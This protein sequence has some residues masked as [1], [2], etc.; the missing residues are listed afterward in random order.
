MIQLQPKY[1]LN[2]IKRSETAIA[3][4][5]MTVT[6]AEDFELVNNDPDV[7]RLAAADVNSTSS[8]YSSAGRSPET[9]LNGSVKS[10]PNL[11]TAFTS[12]A[13]AT[14]KSFNTLINKMNDKASKKHK[15]TES[16]GNERLLLSSPE[17]RLD[18][19]H[20][21]LPL[22]SNSTDQIMGCVNEE[23]SSLSLSSST[24]KIETINRSEKLLAV[25]VAPV[26]KVKVEESK[27]F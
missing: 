2:Y 9:S 6:T 5:I 10:Q 16:V 1:N 25:P 20:Q 17:K 4:I 19:R 24:S 7:L 23:G 14:T 26:V 13:N 11:V 15:K 12:A 27:F 18:G 21:E 3:P 22:R 8:S